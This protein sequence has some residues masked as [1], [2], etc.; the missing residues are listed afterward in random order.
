MNAG[1]DC[2]WIADTL[3]EYL[4]GRLEAAEMDRVR[5]HLEGCADC[6]GRASAVSLL[7]QTPVP[8]PDPERWDE[9][10]EG[11]V[12]AAGRRRGLWARRWGWP[13]A[14]AL[15]AAA[16]LVLIVS[17]DTGGPPPGA[18]G[19]EALAREV[20]EL[21]AA[22]AGAWTAGLSPADF[23]S[24]GFDVSGLSEEEIEQLVT[25]VGRT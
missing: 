1:D 5:R 23:I 13:A 14:A 3:P 9:F 25:E 12:V 11:V 8:R 24:T 18:D 17:R 4:V 19:I 6:R 21:P 22:E 16:V 10:V 7:Q 15:V 20:A 2:T